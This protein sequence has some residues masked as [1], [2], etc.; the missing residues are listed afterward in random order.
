MYTLQSFRYNNQL[1]DGVNP[2]NQGFTYWGLVKELQ[3]VC[4][5][6]LI[7]ELE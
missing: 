4:D 6:K 1:N 2:T 3:N 7:I 5:E